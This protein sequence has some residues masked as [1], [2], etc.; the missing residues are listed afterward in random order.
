MQ[1]QDP[2]SNIFNLPERRPV[3]AP[4]KARSLAALCECFLGIYCRHPSG[5]VVHVDNAAK[6]LG[7]ERRR[8]YDILNVLN[9]FE[10]FRKHMKSQ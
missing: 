6:A 8:I 4:R 9:G 7:V 1:A 5:T 2:V 3:D 10:L